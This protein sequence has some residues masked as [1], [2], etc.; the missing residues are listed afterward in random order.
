M[1]G[2]S[3]LAHFLAAL[4]PDVVD[5]SVQ[6]SPKTV[7]LTVVSRLFEGH[8]C[9]GTRGALSRLGTRGASLHCDKTGVSLG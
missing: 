2:E 4:S 7:D 5:E 3:H 6:Y 9:G 1:A 8:C